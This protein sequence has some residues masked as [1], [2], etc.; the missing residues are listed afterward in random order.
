MNKRVSFSGYFRMKSFSGFA[1]N[2]CLRPSSIVKTLPGLVGDLPFT[3]ETG[4]V[5][6]GG[7]DDDVQLFYYFIESEGSP[8]DDPLVL[9]ISGGPGCSS[10][11]ALLYEIGPLTLNFETS[12][13]EKP[14]LEIVPDS[15][16]KVASIIFLDQPAGSGFSY[17]K[18]PE[19]Y[20]TNDTLSAIHVY[21]FMKKWLVDHPKFLNN[22]LYL[23]GDSYSGIVVPMIVQEIYNGNEV[24]ERPQINIKGYTLGNPLTDR[25]G[26][27]NSRIQFAHNM[28]LLSDAIYE[29]TKKN[30][31]GDYFKVDPNNSLCIHDLQVVDKEDNYMYSYAWANRR[32]VREALHIR[33]E[34]GHTEWVQC[35]RTLQFYF[36]KKAISY[37]HDVH[38][39]VGYH[40]RLTSKKC[41]A[42]IYSGDHDMAIPYFS[43]LNWIESLNLSVVDDWRP[44]FVDDQVAGYTKKYSRGDYKLTFATVK[45]GGH[46][47]PEYKHK[48]C[49]SML[50]MW[51]AN[52]TINHVYKEML[53]NKSEEDLLFRL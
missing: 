52:D 43:T 37:T 24:G 12:T 46:T 8:K 7:S 41:R 39:S 4:Y 27:Y 53:L 6:I 36:D 19:A 25:S 40:Q 28:A 2:Q 1:K 11:Y 26:D 33:E 32:D 16:T 45:G 29:S 50:K 17:G 49:L 38:S 15:L 31:H 48:E 47:A 10:I 44:W 23:G 42:L 30:C 22:P 21:D 9:W 3:L 13:M 5:R 20:I 51:L 35:N 14:I 18:T 34:Y